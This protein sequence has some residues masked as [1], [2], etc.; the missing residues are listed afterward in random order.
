MLVFCFFCKICTGLKKQLVSINTL[1]SGCRLEKT[2][3]PASPIVQSI[4]YNYNKIYMLLNP[5]HVVL[6][7][8]TS[9]NRVY[10]L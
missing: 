8:I 6:V 10:K 2:K 9:Q 3:S 7:L 5:N 1:Y 4:H